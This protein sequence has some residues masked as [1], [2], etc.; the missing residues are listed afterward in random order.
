MD[1]CILDISLTPSA[2][3]LR[4]DITEID[5]DGLLS[6]PLKLR[7]DPANGCGGVIWQAGKTL[8]KYVIQ[9]YDSE[10][11]KGKRIVELGAGGGF[12]G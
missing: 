9:N 6:P 8:A 10:R 12:V 11:L 1:T 4:P 5:F 2:P 3:L 7:E